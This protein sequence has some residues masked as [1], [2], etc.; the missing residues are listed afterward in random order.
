M[1]GYKLIRSARRT[2]ALEISRD[3]TVTVRA[4]MNMPDEIIDGFVSK[5]E[6]WIE[7]KLAVMKSRE[8]KADNLTESE[9]AELKQKAKEI[10]PQKVERFAEIMGLAPTGVKI[11]SAKKRFGS[12]SGKNSLCFSYRLMLYPDA[13]IDYVVV[14]ELAH[15]KHHNHSAQFY[16]LVEKYLPDYKFRE[17]LLKR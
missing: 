2:L 9:I 17:N 10:I 8:V 6:K 15:I 14:H 4:P 11:T 12:C 7:K 5:H 13:A 1:R 3:L 16:K